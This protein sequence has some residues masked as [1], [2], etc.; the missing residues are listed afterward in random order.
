MIEI[1]N[2]HLCENCFEE[3]P[4]GS[5]FCTRCG[6]NAS[7]TPVDPTLLHPG[8]VLLGKYVIGKVI[9][10][11]GFGVTYLAYDA[12]MDRK[13]AIKEFFPYGLALRA[14]GTTIVSVSSED[15]VEAFKLGSEKFYN[16]AKLVSK[17]NGNPNIVGV[18]EFFYEN[19]T[20]YFVMEYLKGSTLKDYIAENG[21]LS[22]AQALFIAQ[23]VSN[24]LMASH[25]SNVLHRDISPDNIIICEN[26]DVKLIDFGAAR[27]VV[28]ERSQSFSVILKPGFAP[29]EQ[30]QKKGNQGPWTDIYSLGAT[31]YYALTG[32]IPEDPMSRLDN[33]ETFQSNEYHITPELWSFIQKATQIRI[34]D[35]YKDIFEVKNALNNVSFTSEPLKTAKA[36]EMPKFTT[37]QPYG[38]SQTYSTS[39]QPVQQTTMRSQQLPQ[40]PPMTVSSPVQTMLNPNASNTGNAYA[41]QQQPPAPPKKK[42]PRS[43]LIAIIGGIVACVALAIIIPIVVHNNAKN[44]IPTNSGTSD[45]TATSQSIE[46]NTTSNSNNNNSN[47][48]NSTYTPPTP[49]YYSLTLNLSCDKNNIMNQYGVNV[50]IDDQLVYTLP[51]GAST[52]K[53]INGL[54]PGNHTLEFRLAG[55]DINGQ[56]LYQVSDPD[57]YKIYT[58]TLNSNFSSSFKFHI[59]LGNTLQ[60]TNY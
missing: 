22:P 6:F 44:D 26:G 47:N 55:N 15:N 29:L 30:Y 21:V 12:V 49:T 56:P 33:D 19:D 60:V 58:V 54:S 34:E 8:G 28:A 43:G 7:A 23:N 31:I 1:N 48:N 13:V 32:D 59:A 53:T 14:P 51:H 37:A 38:M 25:S 3:I 39:V 57:S 52:T 18:H 27:Q 46:S 9:G 35:R 10:K 45:Y 41:V 16:E 5:N 42:L 11:G 36:E 17:F 20:V 50:L 2:K 4:A 40:N 24:A